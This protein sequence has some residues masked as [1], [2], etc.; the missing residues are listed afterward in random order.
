MRGRARFILVTGLLQAVLGTATQAALPDGFNHPEVKWL[1]LE[2]DHFLLVYC[3]GLEATARL[4]ARILEDTHPWMCEELG[5]FPEAKTTVILA[6]FDDVG[7]NNFARRMQHTI[8][9]SNPVL[10]QGRVATEQWLRHLLPHEYAHVV[11]GWALRR[12]GVAVGPLIEWTGMELQPQWFT[13]GLAEYLANHGAKTESTFAELAFQE[14]RLLFG[15]KLDI[16][17]TRFD[18]METSVVYRQGLSMCIYLAERYGEDVFR[19]I[20]E[21]Y[22]H[23]PQ[24]EIAF[25]IATGEHIEH[26]SHG[27]LKRVKERAKALP[28]AEA[29]DAVSTQFEVPLEAA[30]G[31][32]PSPDGSRLAVYGVPDWEQPIPALFVVDAD[33]R[34]WRKVAGNLDLYD[35]WKMSWSPDGRVLYY[36]GRVK[37]GTG[38]IRNGLFA[39]DA[40][41]KHGWRVN[42]GDLRLSEPELSPDGTRIAFT[43]YLGE[44]TLV[45]VMDLSGENVH[46]LTANLTQNCFSP[47]WSPDGKRLAFSVADANGTDLAVINADG[48][49]FQQL[50]SDPWPDQYPTWHPDGRSLAFVSYRPGEGSGERGDAAVAGE[51]EG[52]ASASTNIYSVPVGGGPLTQ[53]TAA[54]SGGAYYPRYNDNGRALYVSLFKVRDAQIRIVDL[55]G[56]SASRP[57]EP[58]GP[59]ADQPVADAP[60]LDDAI[61]QGV[62]VAALPDAGTG[63]VSSFAPPTAPT[64]VMATEAG[65]SVEAVAQTQRPSRPPL[66]Q[67]T[68]V[69]ATPVQAGAV[70]TTPPVE[71]SA[72]R[73]YRAGAHLNPY[74]TRPFS[75]NDGLGDTIGVR[76]RVTDPLQQHNLRAQA[77][78]GVESDKVQYD[79]S[80][81]NDQTGVR[82]GFDL[83]R[84]VPALR[85]ERGAL[86]AETSE[87]FQFLGEVPLALTGNPY[88]KDTFKFGYEYN[89]HTPFRT[90]GAILTPPPNGGITAG[91][92]LGYERVQLLPG[93]GEQELQAKLSRSDHRFGAGLDFWDANLQWLGRFYA[94]SPRAQFGV[95]AALDWF[96]GQDFDLNMTSQSVFSGELRY[97]WRVADEVLSRY[98]WPYLH[99]GPV[100]LEASYIYRQRFN[101][102]KASA[103][104]TAVSGSD[105][106]DVATIGLKN[107]GYLTRHAVYELRVMQRYYVGGGFPDQSDFLALLR[108]QW[109]DLPF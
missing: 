109:R 92:S 107:T 73:T 32:T 2:T 103:G 58:L 105:L 81:Y 79:L 64:D 85:S 66:V 54:T 55:A 28:E 90:S 59:T 93:V 48:T 78:Y 22:A 11:N 76:V 94:P 45:G 102:Q 104:L 3:D 100:T 95:G 69:A 31:A 16:P 42:T 86:V 37:T 88:A 62:L 98:T 56:L 87:G 44:Q 91:P 9:L 52:I 4:A 21:Q 106:R 35:S 6:D 99:M 80:Y 67:P 33:G 47:T 27:W 71:F 34:H 84:Q 25:Y 20:L 68:A 49:G 8:Y 10:N 43:G 29:L 39:Y 40:E 83:H 19:R 23:A 13:E 108:F 63:A 18:V 97:D 101:R 36:I 46:Y 5:A 41:R 75:G 38:A 65:L 72:P 50:T 61:A 12:F 15:A 70:D 96:A 30:L 60:Q 77:E 89:D 7:F 53:L 57:A 82:M 24:W 1:E 51:A 74:L 26:F 14:G 17:D